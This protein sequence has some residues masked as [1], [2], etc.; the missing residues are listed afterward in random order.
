M[1]AS[2][3]A[4]LALLGCPVAAMAQTAVTQ[5]AEEKARSDYRAARLALERKQPAIAL[6]KFEGVIK[7]LGNRPDLLYLAAQAAFQAEKSGR[8][9]ELVQ[10]CFKVADEPFK[11]SPEYQG[12][13][14]LAARI[15]LEGPEIKAWAR[16]AEAEAQ[17]RAA[18]ADLKRKALADGYWVDDRTRLMW[19][20]RDNGSGIDGNHAI[21]YC[22]SLRM[23]GWADWRQPTIED[24]DGVYDRSMQRIKHPLELSPGGFWV[25]SATPGRSRE[26]AWAL[27]FGDGAHLEGRLSFKSPGGR[28]LCVRLPPANASKDVDRETDDLEFM[29]GEITAIDEA[30]KTITVKPYQ[31]TEDGGAELLTVSVDGA[32]DITDGEQDRT[33]AS[34]APGTEVD[35][36]Y[37]SAK[38]RATYIF[39]Y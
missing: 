3:L 15:E 37:D 7:V 18:A 26:W 6:E 9:K 21:D 8:A 34:L 11:T 17:A 13:I 10:Q 1:R 28:A 25:W 27:V 2:V 12:L 33:L 14:D 24:L 32:T 36:E 31:N 30:A 4:I 19:T 39:V 23:G 38:K 35:V 16:A 22:R 20:V 5:S 29:S